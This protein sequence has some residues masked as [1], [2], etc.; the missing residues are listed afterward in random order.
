M[1]LTV[2]FQ[3]VLQAK[4]RIAP[5]INVTPVMTSTTL[6]Q[7]TGRQIF[8]KCESFQKTGSFKARG[9]LNAVSVGFNIFYF[10]E[11]LVGSICC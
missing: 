1:S 2:G 10:M 7:A 8:L 9:A 11:M 3:D 4:E 6:N 5:F